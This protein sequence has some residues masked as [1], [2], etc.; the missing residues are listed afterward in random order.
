M[1]ARIDDLTD[2]LVA[3][4][5]NLSLGINVKSSL[6]ACYDTLL[7]YYSPS[8]PVETWK[9]TREVIASSLRRDRL[10]DSAFASTTRASA[11]LVF[12]QGKW[13]S[14]GASVEGPST[15]QE[16][17]SYIKTLQRAA[18]AQRAFL[19]AYREDSFADTINSLWQITE[20]SLQKAECV[21]TLR[22][23]ITS[24]TIALLAQHV[25]G[26]A[27]LLWGRVVESSLP[28]LPWSNL[29]QLF[30]ESSERDISPVMD[31]LEAIVMA[32][33]ATFS[34]CEASTLE[35]KSFF[36]IAARMHETASTLRSLAFRPKGSLLSYREQVNQLWEN[37]SNDRATAEVL[38]LK[39]MN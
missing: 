23:A 12:S 24:H 19:D 3:L 2:S 11:L 4:E 25:C 16:L 9:T 39:L 27:S 33:M 22:L 21:A 26:N 8:G 31:S 13:L 6:V 15:G 14:L 29:V 18:M 32:G 38:Y 28:F 30:C 36:H 35:S 17:G 7:L 20:S 34:P 10:L 5:G 1:I 37:V